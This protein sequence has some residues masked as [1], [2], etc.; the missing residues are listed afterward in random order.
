MRTSKFAPIGTQKKRIPLPP[1]SVQ[2]RIVEILDK[3]TE[4]EAE[5]DCR[6]RQYEYY[7]NQLLAFTP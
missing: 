5:L 3:F 7:R 4:L 2:H 6:K 1:L